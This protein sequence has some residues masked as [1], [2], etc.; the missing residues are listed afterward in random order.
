MKPFI[1]IALL[2]SA[3]GVVAQNEASTIYIGKMLLDFRYDPPVVLSAQ[4]KD[5]RECAASICDA[6]G[7]LLFY[8]NGGVSPTAPWPGG[9]FKP[10]HSFMQNGQ[11]VDSGGCLSSFMGAMIL[12]DPIGITPTNRKYYLFTKDCVESSFS[13]IQYNSGLTYSIIDMNASNGAGAVISKYNQL[14]PYHVLS[15]HKTA[16]EPV[17]AVLDSD[18]ELK[19]GGEGYWLFSYTGDSLYHLHFGVNGFDH[20]QKLVPGEGALLVSPDRNHLS[21]GTKLYRLDPVL[22][23]VEFRE[24]FPQYSKIAFSPDGSKMYVISGENLYQY[25]LNQPNVLSTEFYIATL[26]PNSGLFLAPSKRI[27]IYQSEANFIDAQIVCANNSG[28]ACGWDPSN[29]SLGNAAFPL[30]AEIRPNIPAH[31]LFGN[32]TNCTLGIDELGDSHLN[33]R[34]NPVNDH[35]FID[36]LDVE[37]EYSLVNNLGQLV[38]SGKTDS[39]SPVGIKDLQE[40]TYFIRIENRFLPVIKTN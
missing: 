40:G 30:G 10:D 26:A 34:P 4:A 5:S 31:Y 35:F 8:S 2:N 28:A 7:N 32:T 24:E 27:I 22:G 38:L 36:G 19:S 29:I 20:F 9:V 39:S 33:I 12:P 16:Y 1:L 25:D 23:T 14:V 3:F 11:M 6:D 37:T 15:S 18:G 21:V 17:T 13:T